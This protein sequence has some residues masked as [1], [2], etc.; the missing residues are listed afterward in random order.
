MIGEKIADVAKKYIGQYEKPG[1]SGFID[2]LFQQR[3]EEVGWKEGDAW[4]AY[5]TELVWKEAYGNQAMIKE[6][7]KLFNGSVIQTFKNFQLD[8]RWSI[9][10]KPSVGSLVIWRHGLTDL[11]HMGIVLKVVDDD[12]FQTIE[13]NSNDDGA[14]EGVKVV[15]KSRRLNAP[16]RKRGLNLVAFIE[17]KELRE[18]E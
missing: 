7:D 14:R 13:G 6:L 17:P 18:A 1:N 5:F 10:V 16:F 2:P 11:G 3:M 8:G 12:I 15:L 4:C 9:A